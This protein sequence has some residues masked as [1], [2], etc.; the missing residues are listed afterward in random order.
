MDLNNENIDFVVLGTNLTESL[1][2]TGLSI[3]GKKVMHLDLTDRYGGVLANFN[4]KQFIELVD[5]WEEKS[6]TNTFLKGACLRDFKTID[7]WCL[8]QELFQSLSRYFSLDLIPKVI[9]SK[10]KAV[11]Y[12]L[13]SGVSFYLE[14]QNIVNNYIFLENKFMKIPFSKSEVFMN[15]DLSLKDKRNLVK[16]INHWL[17]FYDKY[18]E[19]DA[20]ERD[21]NSTHTYEKDIYVSDKEDL[22]FEE[23][24][25]SPIAL[26]LEH[27]K[28]DSNLWYMLLYALGNVNESQE[29]I[30]KIILEKIT[31]QEFFARIAK[32]LRSIGYY[33]HTP[34]LMANYGTSEYVQSFSR[35]GSIYGSIYILDD[36][37]YTISEPNIVDNRLESLKFSM[38]PTPIKPKQGF[39]IGKEYEH[40]FDPNQ[41]AEFSSE[42]WYPIVCQ[43]MVVITHI[44]LSSDGHGPPIYS[45]PPCALL[46]NPHPIRIIQQGVGSNITPGGIFCYHISTVQTFENKDDFTVL[47]NLKDIIFDLK[48]IEGIKIIGETRKTNK[49]KIIQ[50]MQDVIDRKKQEKERLKRIAER[51]KA[52]NQPTV[53]MNDEEAM[54]QVNI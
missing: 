17:H 52:R 20:E 26:Y 38:N 2:G 24:K 5:S 4:L 40:I 33:G 34:M 48:N 45:I 8:H 43:R 21:Q 35:V 6:K 22:E 14:F 18:G 29:N 46:S 53:D 28:I 54:I 27:H 15:K 11:N 12:C 44:E 16:I 13:D 10:S 47:K 50:H 36:K 23:Y 31:T 9:F 51:E 25:D 1:L 19:V 32:Y 30:D 7:N 37:E 42:T 39:I 49:D 3:A 41:E